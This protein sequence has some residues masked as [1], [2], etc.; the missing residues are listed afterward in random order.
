MGH[1]G[2]TMELPTVML[3]ACGAQILA[4]TMLIGLQKLD[5]FLHRLVLMRRAERDH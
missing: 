3:D 4:G 2:A 1:E 5:G